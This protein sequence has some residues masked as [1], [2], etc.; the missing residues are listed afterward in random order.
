MLEGTVLGSLA[1]GSPETELNGIESFTILMGH[2]ESLNLCVLV[3]L[4]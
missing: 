2:C 1:L 3:M 4:Q